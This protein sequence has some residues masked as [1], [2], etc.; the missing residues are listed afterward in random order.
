MNGPTTDEPLQSSPLFSSSSHNH[1]PDP[2]PTIVLEVLASASNRSVR[3]QT[4]ISPPDGSPF[5]QQ[6]PLEPPSRA[7]LTPPPPPTQS[8]SS[9]TSSPKSSHGGSTSHRAKQ[10]VDADWDKIQYQRTN[11][12]L[13]ASSN[14][15]TASGIT[16]SQVPTP[17]VPTRG[18]ILNFKRPPDTRID[19]PDSRASSPGSTNPSSSTKKKRRI[20]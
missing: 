13:G 10:D 16:P 9:N 1:L 7:L 19:R 11:G 2:S 8:S 14:P 12:P 4:S 5:P 18:I 6:E 3:S 20:E 17:T 15:V